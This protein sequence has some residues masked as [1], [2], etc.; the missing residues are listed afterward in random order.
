MGIT[1]VGSLNG[2]ILGVECRNDAGCAHIENGC[3]HINTGVL[4]PKLG[5]GQVL[6]KVDL[7]ILFERRIAIIQSDVRNRDSDIQLSTNLES[8]SI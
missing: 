4:L 2:S 7:E 3:I 6:S 1:G 8:F 5:V